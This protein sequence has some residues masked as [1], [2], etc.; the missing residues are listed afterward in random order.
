VGGEHKRDRNARATHVKIKKILRVLGLGK[1]THDPNFPISNREISKIF[2]PRNTFHTPR[3]NHVPPTSKTNPDIFPK[4]TLSKFSNPTAPTVANFTSVL[5]QQPGKSK[6]PPKQ[7]QPSNR[8][9]TPKTARTLCSDCAAIVVPSS[10]H[11][12][13][14]LTKSVAANR[15][16]GEDKAAKR[17]RSHLIAVPAH[18]AAADQ[19]KTLRICWGV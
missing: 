19:E 9:P 17:G 7:N 6:I 3:D 16:S 4:N 12:G 13:K 8:T 11:P 5:S 1:Q 15:G 14:E 2:Q 10:T 18:K